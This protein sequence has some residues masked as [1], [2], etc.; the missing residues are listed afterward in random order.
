MPQCVRMTTIYD[1]YNESKYLFGDDLPKIMRM[2]KREVKWVNKFVMQ[3][4]LRTIGHFITTRPLNRIGANQGVKTSTP[5]LRRI[6]TREGSPSNSERI[7]R[8]KHPPGNNYEI[9]NNKIF[10]K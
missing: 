10:R 9:R 2:P 8:H 4:N 6:F 1:E 7:G 5:D 3:S